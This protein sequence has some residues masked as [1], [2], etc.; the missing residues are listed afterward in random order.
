MRECSKVASGRLVPPSGPRYQSVQDTPCPSWPLTT[1]GIAPPPT[2]PQCSGLSLEGQ[3]AARLAVHVVCLGFEVKHGQS[4]QCPPPA[5]GQGREY[6]LPWVPP[7][8]G[9]GQVMLLP[10]S[11]QGR[12]ALT[13]DNHG[14]SS[15]IRTQQARTC[16]CAPQIPV[17]SASLLLLL[18]IGNPGC[19]IK[20]LANFRAQGSVRV[21]GGCTS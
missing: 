9:G 19:S 11:L 18:G 1:G 6:W 20:S 12:P 17:F 14:H 5:Q 10:P 15:Y 2:R 3:A 4:A 8:C 7:I 21:R 16:P 13:T